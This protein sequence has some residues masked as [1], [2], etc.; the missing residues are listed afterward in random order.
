LPK[1]KTTNISSDE[2][3]KADTW[4]LNKYHY[5]TNE[6]QLISVLKDKLILVILEPNPCT[7]ELHVAKSIMKACT[8]KISTRK[9]HQSHDTLNIQH[10]FL[11]AKKE[12]CK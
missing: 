1:Q 8:L 9:G 12:F 11:T 10:N 4:K 2:T 6:N 7:R 5:R 3:T